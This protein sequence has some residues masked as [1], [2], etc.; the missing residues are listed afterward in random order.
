VRVYEDTN[1]CLHTAAYEQYNIKEQTG[2]VLA[3]ERDPP[4]AADEFLG[5]GKTRNTSA[6]RL[7]AIAKHN[8][9]R[10]AIRGNGSP[11]LRYISDTGYMISPRFAHLLS[12]RAQ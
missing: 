3:G 12:K 10:H 1:S 8:L 11:S 7:L 5:R 2:H 6:V 9:L 4:T